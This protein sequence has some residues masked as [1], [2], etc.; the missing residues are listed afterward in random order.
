MKRFLK[1]LAYS[2]S[3]I[4]LLILFLFFIASIYVKQNKKELIAEA[5]KTILEKY[6]SKVLI[7]D[8]HLSLLA[9]FPNL[10]IQ[11][12]EV[13]VEGPMFHIHHQKLFQAKDI[14]V[15]IKTW[16]LF[17]GKIVLSKTKLNKGQLFIYT[18][19]LGN[20]NLDEFKQKQAAQ[21]KSNI[22]IPENIELNDFNIIIKDDQK[23]KTFHFVIKSLNVKS[24]ESNTETVLSIK[25]EL[26]VKS[27]TFNH[28]KGSF[29][30]DQNLNGNYTIKI[31][32]Q[33]ELLSFEKIDLT[34]GKTPFQLS[35]YFELKK[36]GLF[37]LN[38]KTQSVPFE[39][40]KSILTKNLNK[41]LNH[42]IITNPLTID[43]NIKGPLSGGEPNVIAHWKTKKT[44]IGTTQIQFTNADVEGTFDNQ[45]NKTLEPNDANSSIVLSKLS[46]NWHEI[47][48][49]T[50]N[51]QIQ[52]LTHPHL[53]GG[54]NTQFNLA[55]LNPPLNTENIVIKNGRGKI[56]IEFD[57]PLSELTEKNTKIIANLQISN[58]E[59]F[60]KPIQ[61]Y[62]INT[63][64]NIQVNNNTIEIKKLTAQTKEGSQLNITGISTQSLAA[65]PNTPGKAN[66]QLNINSPYLDLNNFSS[67]LQ[68]TKAVKKRTKKNS[69]SKIDH[70]LENE[71]ININ[72]DAK[73][74]KW[75]KLIA[76]NLKSSIN[77][78]TGNWQ[79]NNLNMNVGR[80]S[81]QLSTKMVGKQNKKTI[82]AKYQVNKVRAEDLLYGMNNFGLTGLSYKNIQGELNING[83]LTS[84]LN[85]LGGISPNQIKA[86]LDFKIKDGALLNYTPLIKLQQSIFKK[87]HLDS[88]QFATLQNNLT[89]QN[90]NIHI[91][92]MEI[93][94]S[95]LNVFV[96]GD[97][98]LNG[99]TNLHIQVPLNNFTQKDQ[100]K[101]M[102]TAS[103][104]EKGG[105][106]IFLKAVSDASGQVKLTIDS[107]GSQYKREQMAQ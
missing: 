68:E 21:K 62:I 63:H 79:L 65:I 92:R 35:G 10:S 32:K 102:K 57:G 11:L 28:L 74:I 72:L 84:P 89:I 7:K 61:K 14:S 64:A 31:Q 77:L 101:K 70:I 50:S 41:V 30:K 40:A 98:G 47:P 38:I 104:K 48:I 99:K 69:F 25:K 8:I 51:I 22:Q 24:K 36:E 76:T 52:N 93:A 43:A 105:T 23:L 45:I 17:G 39:F 103:N 5:S 81:I 95:A 49:Q 15:R 78:N 59:I 26:V 37:N 33:K 75:Q 20:H 46:G 91:P 80:G 86:T 73:R 53:K 60:I 66:I 58:A 88:L 85:Q 82:T 1:W 56:N 6:H 87:R 44:T 67:S 94:T 107:K 90:G 34:I 18:D 71:T 27:L 2:L 42:I 100:T 97:Y 12:T 83:Q 55:Q 9:Q 4:V 3:S 96:G 13:D 16:P 54:F 29:L 19:K 106:S